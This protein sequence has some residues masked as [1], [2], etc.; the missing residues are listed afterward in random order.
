[1]GTIVRRAGLFVFLIAS[2]AASASAAGPTLGPATGHVPLGPSGN[3]DENKVYSVDGTTLRFMLK[4]GM[5]ATPI[6]GVHVWSGQLTVCDGPTAC[7]ELALTGPD[8]P[9]GEW[10]G[11]KFLLAFVVPT[12]LTI[13]RK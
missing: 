12:S 10:H 11:F 3:I 9:P 8:Q 4:N 13:T 1:M 7:T 5:R 2:A 6:S